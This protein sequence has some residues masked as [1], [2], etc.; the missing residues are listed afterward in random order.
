MIDNAELRTLLKAI[1]P[2]VKSNS[3]S[4]M[5]VLEEELDLLGISGSHEEL[6]GLADLILSSDSLAG[7]L[8][9]LG[10]TDDNK[11]RGGAQRERL[12]LEIQQEPLDKQQQGGGGKREKLRLD[13]QQEEADKEQ[14]LKAV[15]RAVLK[16][17]VERENTNREQLAQAISKAIAEVLSTAEGG[18]A[19][20]EY[21]NYTIISRMG[22]N[23]YDLRS[24]VRMSMKQG[25]VPLGG[26]HIAGPLDNGIMLFSQ[27][28]GLPKG[29]P[30]TKQF[31]F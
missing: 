4:Y 20:V 7:A 28:M 6:Y 1:F 27:A 5:T 12:R 11:L 22:D 29:R 2:S 10:K 26:I 18:G 31:E 3:D 15:K 23:A 25:W 8:E 19:P 9:R 14:N 30:K 17:E 21:Q 16:P 24:P 13:A